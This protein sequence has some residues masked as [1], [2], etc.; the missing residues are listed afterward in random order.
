M[1][2]RSLLAALPLM[3]AASVRAGAQRGTTRR[4][5]TVYKDPGCGCCTKWSELL[6]QAGFTITIKES[7]E[8]DT[9]KY[10]VPSALRSC[11]TAV[12]DGHIV[13]GHVPVA[14]IQRMLTQGNAV[15]GLAVP[16]M[17]IGS[18]GMEVAG[19]NPQAYRV[20]A[21]DRTGAS[22]VFASYP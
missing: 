2:R 15:Y 20:M 11:H 13:E 12:V 14:D 4:A 5:V 18:P 7:G 9:A 22:R 19:V 17:P 6:R 10:A 16:G 21:F 8:L 3:M 1:T